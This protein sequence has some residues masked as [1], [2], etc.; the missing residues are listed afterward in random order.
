MS[1]NQQVHYAPI[2]DG[3]DVQELKLALLRSIDHARKSSAEV[4][5]YK[6]KLD[7]ALGLIA[8]LRSEIES[9]RR[10]HGIPP[11]QTALEP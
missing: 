3:G 5:E 9:L 6:A 10:S 8:Q 7:G 1:D 2:I 11:D 4:A